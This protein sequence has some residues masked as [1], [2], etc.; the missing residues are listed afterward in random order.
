MPVGLD[1]NAVTQVVDYKRLVRFCEP[2]LPRQSGVLDA[3][4]LRGARAAVVAL[5]KNVVRLRLGDT[6][7]DNAD[8]NLRHELD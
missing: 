2:E 7:S 6:R 3:T 4:P 5:D 1:D 8:A